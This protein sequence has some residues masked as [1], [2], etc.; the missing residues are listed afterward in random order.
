LRRRTKTNSAGI[1][2]GVT[3]RLTILQGDAMEKTRKVQ[4]T[5][6][7]CPVR[8]VSPDMTG[9][10]VRTL[11]QKGYKV[12]WPHRDTNQN[13][14]TGLQICRENLRAIKTA[15]VIHVIWDGKSQGC[16]FDLGMAFALGK[17]VIPLQLPDET[18]DKSF[19]NMVRAWAN[20]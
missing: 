11:E 7:I 4:S 3:D 17:P 6:L 19:Q 12:H 15:T 16:L 5:F 9:A 18:P 8:G 10:A 14:S 2:D 13:D 20:E 1:G